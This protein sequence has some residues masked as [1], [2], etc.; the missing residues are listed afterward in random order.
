MFCLRS[1]VCLWNYTLKGHY[2]LKGQNHAQQV[3]LCSLLA[4]LHTPVALIQTGFVPLLHTAI[5]LPVVRELPALQVVL[6][7]VAPA[8]QLK[9]LAF[10]GVAGLPV[11]LDEPEPAFGLQC[12][13]TSNLL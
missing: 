8:E 11:Q 7:L 9:G 5:K 13:K 1:L 12:R 2:T 4:G 10:A 3:E 6:Q